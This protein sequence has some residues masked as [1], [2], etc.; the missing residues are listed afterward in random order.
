MTVEQDVSQQSVAQAGLATRIE[1]LLGGRGF[2]PAILAVLVVQTIAVRHL[3]GRSYFFAEDFLF[4]QIYDGRANDVELLTTNV[5][6]HLV[7]GFVLVNKYFGA[8]LGADWT[9]A[10]FL[11]LAVQLL[12]TLGFVRLLVALVG[13]RWWVPLLTGAFGL[14]VVCLNTAPWWAATVTIQIAFAAWIW[15]LD[16]IVRYADTRRLR[17]LALMVAGYAVALAFWEKSLAVCA[18]AGLLSLIVGVARDRETTTAMDRLRTTVGL[19]PVWVPLGV[20][21]AIDLATYASGDYLGDAGDTAAPGEMLQFLGRN[22]T[23]GLAPAFFGVVYRPDAGVL[24]LLSWLV[25]SVALVAL[26]GWTCWRSAF[27]RRVWAWFLISDVLSQLLVARGRLS[28]LGIDTTSRELRYQLDA[29]LL[30][31]LAVALAVP[32][33]VRASRPAVRPRAALVAVAVPVLCLPL[34]ASSIDYLGDRTPG[35]ASAEYFDR[36]RAGDYPRD[37]RF[38]DLTVPGWIVP[39]PMY[40]WNTIGRIL[41]VVRPDA[42]LTNDP[43]GAFGIRLD[44]RV[45]PL[46]LEPVPSSIPADSGGCLRR[47]GSLDLPAVTSQPLSEFVPTVF[48]FAYDAEVAVTVH[49]YT[50]SGEAPYAARGLSERALRLDAGTGRFAL[51][52]PPTEGWAGMRV[53]LVGRGSVCLSELDY[54]VV[55]AD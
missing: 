51:V 14:S 28:V 50:L 7:P 52:V 34:W 1:R 11:T 47:G 40:P 25:P 35:R 9:A 10:S 45:V 42:R 16:A 31:L 44:G 15:S 46:R 4:L 8:W 32:A 53:A 26:A 48:T 43:E 38:L 29:T 41:P 27:A 30:L 18:Y 49:I 13:R 23:E 6:G 21:S 12:G 37:A 54:A 3:L 33:A 24:T 5:F 19:W 22:V 36:L 17:Y 2:L 55:R 20:L 39:P